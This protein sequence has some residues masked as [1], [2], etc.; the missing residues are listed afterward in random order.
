M[1]KEI[2]ISEGL[3]DRIVPLRDEYGGTE[4][5][6]RFPILDKIQTDTEGAVSGTTRAKGDEILGDIVEM[7]RAEGNDKVRLWNMLVTY[8]NQSGYRK[9]KE[10]KTEILSIGC[11]DGKDA[12]A[13]DEFFGEGNFGSP[14][15]NINYTGVDVDVN[16]IEK[17]IERNK[18]PDFSAQVTKYKLPENY[19]FICG[20]ATD[21]AGL[22]GVPLKAD[23]VMIR[24]QQIYNNEEVW[25]KIF[26]NALE[27]VN[28]DGIII[29]TSFSDVE[30][31]MMI[32]AI[33]TLNC[34]LLVNERN[35]FA[36]VTNMSPKVSIDRNVLILKKIKSSNPV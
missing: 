27:R 18:R 7:A 11:G 5:M 33:N 21:L 29:I 25:R 24:H 28:E 2:T 23:V 30:H 35:K 12:R 22:K 16:A 36:M 1:D 19:Q 26:Q 31:E 13:L 6:G 4:E 3:P 15:D 14:S 17:A 20:D 9:P 32:K 34:E 10:R 8:V